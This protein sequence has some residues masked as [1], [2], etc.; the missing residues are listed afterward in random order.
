[1]KKHKKVT[2]NPPIRTYVNKKEN[3]IIFRIKTGYYLQLLT[4]ET[5]KSLG[6]T[7]SKRAKDKNGKILPNLEI[8][9]VLL[10]PL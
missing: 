3:R 10:S 8:I 9:E 5:I 7:K 2:D 6:S 1:M 4:P